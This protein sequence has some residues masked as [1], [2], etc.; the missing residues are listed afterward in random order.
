MAAADSKDIK[1]AMNVS[2]NFRRIMGTFLTSSKIS[3]RDV[4]PYNAVLIAAVK[5][6]KFMIT[7]NEIDSLNL[8]ANL[9]TV[10]FITAAVFAEIEKKCDE[11][12]ISKTGSSAYANAIVFGC[13]GQDYY[14]GRFKKND[15]DDDDKSL[16]A[17][18]LEPATRPPISSA[19]TVPGKSFAR[20]LSA[21]SAMSTPPAIAALIGASSYSPASSSP[22][23]MMT[24]VPKTPKIVVNMT[25]FLKS[26]KAIF[27]FL[28]SRGAINLK[29]EV[30]KTINLSTEDESAFE[31]EDI[32][33][34]AEIGVIA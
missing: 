32:I 11:V 5:L 20:A 4:N 31:V 25:E 33:T 13:I 30:I 27:S 1:M 29:C 24:P 3:G 28:R 23:P 14:V 10:E 12:K 21:A 16:S 26:R 18:E 2:F 8:L 19:L 34:L 22:V 6:A 7:A 15:R 17:E 9:E